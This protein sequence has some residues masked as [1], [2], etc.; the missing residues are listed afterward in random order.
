MSKSFLL[1][2][3][4][5][6]AVL[7][8]LNMLMISSLSPGLLIKQLIAWIVG[9]ILFF[10]GKQIDP[11]STKSSKYL[12]FIGSCFF[13]LLPILL[14]TITRGS[15]RWIDIGVT[16]IQPSEFI[17]PWLL[18]FLVN[19][20][21]Q[22]LLIIPVFITLLQPDLGSAITIFSL[23][24]PFILYNK[25]LFKI[26]VISALLFIL[27][28]PLIWQFGLHDYQR[29][30]VETFLNPNI[31]PM[32]KGYNV[33]QSKIAI[34]SGGLF[35]KGYK[36]GTQ[37]QLMFL[38][39]KHTDFIFA[40]ISEELGMMGAFLIIGSY[41]VIIKTLFSKAYNTTNKSLFLFTLAIAFQIWIQSIINI[42]MN[43]GLLPV[44]GIPLPLLSVGG[45]SII[46]TLFS[47]GIIYSS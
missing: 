1:P 21:K 35:G 33:I 39:E 16:T 12:I 11:N 22:W 41:F 20:S 6:V 44:T 5:S 13:V 24:I 10:V 42:G 19:T 8:C 2:V 47:L 40:G 32:G 31:D 17:K 3:A 28:S 18:L 9:I 43:L 36:K 4:I 37:G 23:I 30:R 25:K 45:T 7:F 26:A 29:H 34:G 27:V 38:P 15:R 14:N 46:T